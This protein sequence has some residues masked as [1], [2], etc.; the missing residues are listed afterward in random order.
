MDE[1]VLDE[2]SLNNPNQGGGMQGGQMGGG[3]PQG[4]G[5]KRNQAVDPSLNQQ[6][7]SSKRSKKGRNQRQGVDRALISLDLAENKRFRQRIAMYF[8]LLDMLT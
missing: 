8:H 5:Q 3:G 6:A 7:S 4:R 2:V 1:V